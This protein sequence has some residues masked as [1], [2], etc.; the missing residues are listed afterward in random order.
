MKVKK[1]KIG[2]K[3]IGGEKCRRRHSRAIVIRRNKTGIYYHGGV[4]FEASQV[5][6]RTCAFHSLSD[7]IRLAEDRCLLYILIRIIK[8]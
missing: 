8:S 5:Q 3:K 6:Y 1:V 2:R 7:S 4:S